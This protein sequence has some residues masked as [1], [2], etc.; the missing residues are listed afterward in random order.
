[1]VYREFQKNPIHISKRCTRKKW[2]V[3]KGRKRMNKNNKEKKGICML[4]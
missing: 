1:M 3:R 2:G 4:L